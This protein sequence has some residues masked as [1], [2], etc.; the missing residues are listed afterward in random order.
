MMKFSRRATDGF[1]AIALGFA[2]LTA[3]AAA[4]GDAGRAAAPALLHPGDFHGDEI[5]VSADG[6]WLALVSRNS[7]SA[8]EP[9][10]V[11]IR[12]VRDSLVDG[13]QG[14][15]T[16][17]EV[18][19]PGL[20]PLLVVRGI[21][22]LRAG[23]VTEAQLDCAACG[24]PTEFN[25][26]RHFAYRLGSDIYELEAIP[27][28]PDELFDEHSEIRLSYRAAVQVIHRPTR[29]PDDPLWAVLWAGDLDGD[30][31]LDLYLDTADH[32]NMRRRRLLL[33]SA[34]GPGE[35]VGEVAAFQTTGC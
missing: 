34:A 29:V 18:S 8:L 31:L 20:D 19:V 15:I 5:A 23:R 27:L 17:K 1:V 16:G 24:V 14:P 13:D 6:E 25:T 33:S 4:D 35:L 32:Y 11:S 10:A 26:H 3:G 28:Q 22:G 30:G 9:V 2:T 12:P 7:Q 21:P